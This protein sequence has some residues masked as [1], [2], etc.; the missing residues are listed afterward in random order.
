MRKWN[1]Q[2]HNLKFQN[3]P[4][5]VLLLMTKKQIQKLFANN[6]LRNKIMEQEEM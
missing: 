4:E 2:C 6:F 5:P 3:K 1:L